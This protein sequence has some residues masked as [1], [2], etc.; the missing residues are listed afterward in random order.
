MLQMKVDSDPGEF[1]LYLSTT[2]HITDYRVLTL[3]VQN[4]PELLD[5]ILGFG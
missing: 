4:F 3:Y 1:F 5:L 2:P